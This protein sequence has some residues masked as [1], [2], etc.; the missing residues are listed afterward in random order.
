LRVAVTSG[1][2]ASLHATGLIH[3][4]S[5]RGHVVTLCLNV[6]VLNLRRWRAYARQLG[7]RKLWA[8]FRQRH[9]LH[10]A[11][12]EIEPMLHWLRER[13]IA[14]RSVHAACRAVG[15]RLVHVPSLNAPAS[16]AALRAERPDVVVY[17][18]GGILRQSFLD[19]APGGVLNA[20]GGPLP[21]FRGMNAAEWALLHD[22]EPVVT[23]AWLDAGVDTGP[24]LLERPIPLARCESVAALR[25]WGTRVS[26][27]A[28]LDAVDGLARG[29]SRSAVTQGGLTPRPQVPEAGRQYFV[30][31]PPL[32]E[33]VERKLAL[34]RRSP[35][36]ER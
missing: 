12:P 29:P 23:I 18:G 4:L 27:E 16:I 19:A 10:A 35:A 28:L 31:A 1:Y 9:R 17:A 36:G 33:L 26:V 2:R 14:S 7:W 13:R 8:R 3:G 20:H 11:G 30:M 21:R 34:L 15:A 32:L 24:V 6:N 22:V 25:G 5:A